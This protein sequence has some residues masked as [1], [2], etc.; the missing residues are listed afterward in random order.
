M[1]VVDK[2][3]RKVYRFSCP[4]CGSK[5]EAE[6]QELVDIGGKVSKFFFPICRKDRYIGWGDLRKKTV[7]EADN[8]TR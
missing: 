8:V 1:K 7:Y 5:L 4:N 2:E 3:I 6:C